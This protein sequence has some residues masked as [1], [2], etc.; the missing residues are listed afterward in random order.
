VRLRTNPVLARELTE[1]MRRRA[2]P[3]QISLFLLAVIG[4]FASLFQVFMAMSRTVRCIE[5]NCFEEA[6]VLGFAGAGRQLFQTLLFFVVG[7]ACMII[8]ALTAGAI[9]GERERQTLVPLQLTLLSPL[10]IVLGKLSASLAFMLFLLFATL[11]VLGVTFLIGGVSVPEVLKA[12]LMIV[13]VCLMIGA[14]SIMCSALLRRSQGA[15]VAAYG[16]VFV[17]SVG[18]FVPMAILPIVQRFESPIRPATTIF[19]AP[20]PFAATASI[21]SGPVDSPLVGFR[22]E[23]L[24]HARNR[25]GLTPPERALARVP[26]WLFSV[27]A[28]ASVSAG[29]LLIAAWALRTPREEP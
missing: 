23:V 12:A 17:L 27:I 21:V 26:F 18:T 29:A 19:L 8:P 13:L 11:P 24:E 7:L 9:A 25:P 15:T 3:V 28:L 5:G 14:V 4:I 1:R 16:L 20:N 22:S 6:G 2:T 10:Q